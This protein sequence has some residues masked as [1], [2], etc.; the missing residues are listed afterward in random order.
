[1]RLSA[2]PWCDSV[3]R[4]VSFASL[5]DCQI[6]ISPKPSSPI[7]CLCI[8]DEDYREGDEYVRTVVDRPPAIRAK[9]FL[10]TRPILR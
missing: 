8:I 7:S 10:V 2:M 1:M 3:K 5:R 9:H 6:S 4:T